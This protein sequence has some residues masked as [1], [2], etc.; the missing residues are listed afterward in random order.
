V[1]NPKS[2]S[3]VEHDKTAP[4]L[5][6]LSLSMKTLINHQ[7]HVNEIVMV[8]AIVHHSISG[9]SQTIGAEKQFV[10]FSAIRQLGS[11][12]YPSGFAEL[13]SQNNMK[14]EVCKSERGLLNFLVGRRS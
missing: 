12:P 4:P 2:I 7:K 6:C 14:L 5:V 11:M 8:S 10:H 13:V 9:D 1:E 3:V